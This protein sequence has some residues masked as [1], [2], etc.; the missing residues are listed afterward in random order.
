MTPAKGDPPVGLARPRL[1]RVKQLQAPG[2]R[3]P[4]HVA[5]HFQ[6]QLVLAA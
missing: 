3:P 2:G 5:K 1:D 6:R 4:R